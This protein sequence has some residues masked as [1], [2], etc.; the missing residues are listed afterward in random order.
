MKEDRIGGGLEFLRNAE[1]LKDT[2]RSSRTS[3][4]R[5]E[6]AAEHTWRLSLMVI[7]FE[8]EF[9]GV[10]IARLLKICV[11]HDLGEALSGDV[12]APVQS[13]GADKSA[14]ERADLAELAEPLPRAKRNEMM[15]LWDEY[16]NAASREAELVKALDKLETL[17]QHTHRRNG[18]DID[19]A[20]HLSY[21]TERMSTH[22]LF[23]E[24]RER[25]DESTRARMGS[26]EAERR[27]G[28]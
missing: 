21:G 28:R 2:L 14:R 19:H 13:A 1:K 20:F 22:P 18:P 9:A 15:A 4:G 11:L 25:I 5:P 26:A 24:L 27:G 3:A 17:L 10:D 23:A 7:A 6:S 12:P 16:E 8:D